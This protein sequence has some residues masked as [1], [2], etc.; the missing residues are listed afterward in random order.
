VS[1]EPL[2]VS[3]AASR[4]PRRFAIV[5]RGADPGRPAR[6]LC[7]DNAEA[8]LE[9]SKCLVSF[10]WGSPL[11][12][13]VPA[14]L[15]LVQNLAVGTD[16]PP[17]QPRVGSRVAWSARGWRTARRAA[18]TA[19]WLRGSEYPLSSVTSKSPGLSERSVWTT[20]SKP[21]WISWNRPPIMSA[22]MA[23]T[24]PARHHGR[25]KA[26]TAPTPRLT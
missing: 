21:S 8:S 25:P 7:R 4:A 10:Q 16:V 24:S 9:P 20:A 1:P 14:W 15:L 17:G 2:D 5:C 23:G 18:G 12:S 6:S 22:A 3:R 11:A 19:T 13:G 26:R